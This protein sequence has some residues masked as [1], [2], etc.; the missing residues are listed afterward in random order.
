MK[1]SDKLSKML[2]NKRMEKNLNLH[3]A[4]KEI[5]IDYVTLWKIESKG[6]TNISYETA[7]KIAK[8]LEITEKEV[9]ETL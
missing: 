8:F 5:G 3:E 2:M 4:A 1:R 9:R 6:Y 7:R